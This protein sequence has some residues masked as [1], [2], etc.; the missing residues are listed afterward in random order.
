VVRHAGPANGTEENGIVPA[1][2]LEAVSG[3]HVALAV[4]A[5][6][7]PVQLCGRELHSV[8]LLHGPEN[9]LG[10]PHDLDADPVAGDERKTDHGWGA[11]V[12]L[13]SL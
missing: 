9:L 5:L 12:V 10:G 2:H 3:H 13:P 4:V 7:R 8:R 11:T 6:T 1:Q